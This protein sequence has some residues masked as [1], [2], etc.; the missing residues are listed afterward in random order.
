MTQTPETDF[1]QDLIY[2]NGKS[3]VPAELCRKFELEITTLKKQLE[4]E[5]SK[6]IRD[7]QTTGRT[8]QNTSLLG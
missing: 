1:C 3:Y 6:N 2:E 8:G 5:R 4:N 7:R